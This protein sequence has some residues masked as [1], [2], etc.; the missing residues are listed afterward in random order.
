MMRTFRWLFHS[1][2]GH[3]VTR[4]INIGVKWIWGSRH[5]WA[6]SC[7]SKIRMRG[8]SGLHAPKVALL[9]LVMERCR[10]S[11]AMQASCHELGGLILQ[12]PACPLI[13]IVEVVLQLV[14]HHLY[15]NVLCPIYLNFSGTTICSCK[16]Y[17]DSLRL[18]H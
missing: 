5:I 2:N 4:V 3:S 12:N 1:L 15:V 6:V 14:S 9:A 10:L 16:I 7:R 18:C 8:K 17:A 11:D 13:V